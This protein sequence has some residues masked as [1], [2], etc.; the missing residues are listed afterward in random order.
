MR[1]PVGFSLVIA[2]GVCLAVAVP[3]ATFAAGD[4]KP[5]GSPKPDREKKIWTN[6]DVEWLN[7]E[8]DPNRPKQTAAAG[9]A[10]ASA[11]S[12]P[13]AQSAKPAAPVPIVLVAPLDPQQD[14]R[15][16]AQ[17]LDPLEAELDG[18]ESREAQLRGF[19]ATSAGL[20]TGLVLS[21]PCEGITTD[22]LIAQ[23]E[24]RRHE[25]LQEIDALGD[26]SRQNGMSPGILVEGRGRAQVA[27]ESTIE[28]QRAA[29]AQQVRDASEELAQIRGTVSG[30]REDLSAQGIT[31]LPVTPGNGGNMTTDLL[32]QLDGRA[33]AL[34]NQISGAED[35]ARSM[36]VPPADLR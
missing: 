26:V 28:E 34:R 21:A 23:L 4:P 32:D 6:D 15:W 20:P 27:N 5:A 12:A 30:M 10:S 13:G 2:A 22:N 18:I 29:V 3:V 33:S 9:A 31:M 19:R 24:A 17:Q 7:P 1:I 8:F 16:Y 35:V 25:I 11:P 36:G 14:P